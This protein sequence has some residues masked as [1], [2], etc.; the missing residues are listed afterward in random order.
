VRVIICYEHPFLFAGLRALLAP[1]E[2]QVV[3]GTGN[4]LD[5]VRLAKEKEPDIAILDARQD[6]IGATRAIV[7]AGLRTKPVILTV[8]SEPEYVLEALSAG[9]FGYVLKTR[10]GEDLVDCLR[11]VAAG[12]R[13]ISP[14]I[15][16]DPS[17]ESAKAPS[18]RCLTAREH[19]VL[20]LIAEGHTT[21]EIADV[22][23]VEVKTADSHRQRLM[24][25]LNIHHTAGLVR[26][27]IS[28]RVVPM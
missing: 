19:Q 8:H 23:G 12:G 13:F 1:H 25:T 11:A 6:G 4:G 14:G 24:Q 20:K 17:P 9:A 27:A 21:R 2:L 18:L 5:A 15:Q 28:N 16:I 3:G 7:H 26:Y 10:P 22:L